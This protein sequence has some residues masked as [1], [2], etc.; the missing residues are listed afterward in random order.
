MRRCFAG[1]RV[2]RWA[3]TIAALGT[4]GSVSWGLGWHFVAGI[5]LQLSIAAVH[6]WLG[7]HVDGEQ[8]RVRAELLDELDDLNRF[9][10]ERLPPQGR[11]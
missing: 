1:L 6:S 10:L 7:A 4:V 11:A 2:L 3:G 9:V 8:A 5:T